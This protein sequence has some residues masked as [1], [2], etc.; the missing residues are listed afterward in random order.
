M[1]IPQ[2]GAPTG[3]GPLTEQQL[4]FGYWYVTHKLQLKAALTVFLIL[5]SV[6]FGGYAVWGFVK[7]YLID[8]PAYRQMQRESGLT[9]VNYAALENARALDVRT[10]QV[11]DA[12][13]GKVD[14]L[15]LV[16]NPNPRFSATF[17][18]QF[19]GEGAAPPE[20]QGFILPGEEKP[21]ISLGIETQTRFRSARLEIRDVQF[22][23]LDAHEIPEYASYRASRL[24]PL[25]AEDVVLTPAQNPGEVTRV[26]FTAKNGGAYSYWTVRYIVL[27]YRGQSIAAVNAIELSNVLS[28]E[29]RPASVTWFEQIP[30]VTKVEVR[31]EVNILDQNAYI[32]P[33][34]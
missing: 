19:V 29:T 26:T 31:S 21:L 23:R 9:L 15:A 16:R 27:L 17:I 5:W 4:S 25:T 13:A 2:G 8:Y 10:V 7:L 12:G 11:F 20:R 6:G 34:G 18:Y 3:N 28:G 24:A 33:A 1:D 22:T 32:A 30:S 14:A